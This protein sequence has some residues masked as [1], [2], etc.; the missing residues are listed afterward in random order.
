M[1]AVT[2]AKSSRQAVGQLSLFVR[3]VYPAADA[4]RSRFT[5]PAATGL[6]AG[7]PAMLGWIAANI[8]LSC[9]KTETADPCTHCWLGACSLRTQQLLQQHEANPGKTNQNEPDQISPS[10]TQQM[11]ALAGVRRKAGTPP[12]APPAHPPPGQGQSLPFRGRW[13]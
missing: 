2:N 7:F 3:G 13:A 1:A 9:G 12:H 8:K 4:G 5:S 10:P 6:P 11:T